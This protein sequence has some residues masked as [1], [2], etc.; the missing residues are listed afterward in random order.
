VAQQPQQQQQPTNDS[1]TTTSTKATTIPVTSTVTTTTPE[2]DFGRDGWTLLSQGAEARIWQ[3]DKVICKERFTKSYRHP[4]L[5]EQLNKSRG[6][7]EARLLQRCRER[8]IPVP[9]VHSVVDNRIYMA[10]VDGGVSVRDYIQERLSSTSY[11]SGCPPAAAGAASAKD[12]RSSSI[13]SQITDN[14]SA[15]AHLE[16]ERLAH[17]MGKLIAQLHHAGIIHGDLTTSNMMMMTNDNDDD[18]GSKA[19]NTGSSPTSS[20]SLSNHNTIVLIDF[21]LAKSHTSSEERAVDLYVLE[22]AVSSTHPDLP[23]S[24]LP[25]LL[26][27]YEAYIT[28]AEQQQQLA[29]ANGSGSGGGVNVKKN[30]QGTL[31]RLEQVR[32][33]GRKR[34]CFG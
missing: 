11:S 1:T 23:D 34:E 21:G 27:A 4:V 7:A 29:I 31:R 19:T 16:L 15:A 5:D 20:S 32:Q 3:R 18:G 22:R 2:D 12:D 6:R 14:A 26:R 30:Q 8:G 13:S 24:F 17:A 33:R 28:T 10:Y 25:T 9:T